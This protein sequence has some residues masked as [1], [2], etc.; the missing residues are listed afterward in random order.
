MPDLFA[1]PRSLA[2]IGG[3]LLLALSLALAP[4]APA[5][6]QDAQAGAERGD[7]FD[8]LFGSEPAAERSGETADGLALP[9]LFAQGRQISDALAVYDLGGF[10]SGAGEGECI[11]LAPLLDALELD[12][13]NEADNRI[14]VVLPDPRREVTI[15][16]EAILPSDSGPCLPIDRV[17]G[18]LPFALDHDRVSQRLVLTAHAALPVLMRLEREQAYAR[19]RPR[20]YSPDFAVLEPD[21]PLARLWSTDIAAGF[22]YRSGG[23]FDAQGSVLASGELFGLAARA[24]LGLANRSQARLGLTLSDASAEPELL[25]PLRARNFALGD[26]VAP[27]QP[28][29]SDSLAGRGLVISSRA[30]WSVD[31]VDLV[32]LTGPLP[33]GWEAELWQDERLVAVCREGDIAGNWRF[34]GLAVRIGRNRWVVRLHGPHGEM[35]ER[36][37]TRMVGPQMNAENEVEYAFGLV[38][39][40]TP[41]F[42]PPVEG[43]ILEPSGPAA[44][45]TLDWGVSPWLTAR[46]DLRMVQGNG[47][48]LALGMEG[49]L[50]GGLWAGTLAR[51]GEGGLVGA[52]RLAR[53]FGASDLVFDLA[54]YGREAD[55]AAP[56][57]ARENR[58]LMAIEGQGRIGLGRLSLPWQVRLQSAGL[59]S[60]R[61]EQS[62]AARIGLPFA[63]WQA[64]AELGLWRGI[65]GG[66]DGDGEWQGNGVLSATAQIEGW[67]VRG[68]LNALIDDGISLAGARLSATRPVGEGSVAVDL[69]WDANSGALG[70]GLALNRQFGS[71]GM[72]GGIGLGRDGW[73][74]GLGFNLGLW[75][76]GPRWRTTR[77]GIA[78]SGAVFARTFVDADDD[79]EFDRGEE[80]V[81]GARFMVGSALRREETNGRGELLLRGLPAGPGVDIETQLASLPDFSL[82]PIR[83]GDR[84]ELRPGE[85]REL[86]VPLRPTG[87]IEVQVLLQAGENLVPRSGIEVVLRDAAGAETARALS[88]FAGFV[89]FEGLP[90]AE[91]STSVSGRSM[92]GLTI[93]PDRPDRSISFTLPAT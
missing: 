15:P 45:A 93:D 67:R 88:D 33:V 69:D 19:L 42:G 46:L 50:A 83:A 90:F 39:G 30:P 51:Q 77:A 23:E 65:G 29:I 81:E 11:V 27:A 48:A 54:D 58:R 43:A 10:A 80:M 79:G 35:E 44:F 74:V 47:P 76:A 53:R 6:A 38:D 20:T 3:T 12:Y 64:N 2:R 18:F 14:E 26:V 25:G 52:V 56:L 91:Y 28:L 4:I 9:A 62:V 40:G 41:V 31:L 13:T 22:A 78:S 70:G 82:R 57:P 92:D 73:R 84:L 49:E 72:T 36:M 32:E 75:R 8:Q 34:D 7:I 85:V 60:G 68:G 1:R 5:C 16:A 66:D 87:S 86:P 63:D 17:A 59:R 89:L 37:F 24:R 21:T 61:E 71:L 55:P